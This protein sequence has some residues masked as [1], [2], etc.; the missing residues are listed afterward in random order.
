MVGRSGYR[1]D[2]WKGGIFKP[3]I[4]ALPIKI[5]QFKFSTHAAWLPPTNG[6]RVLPKFHGRTKTGHMHYT[7]ASGSDFKEGVILRNL[8]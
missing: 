3:R 8:G 6:N 1:L 7:S 4:F 5:H 2:G